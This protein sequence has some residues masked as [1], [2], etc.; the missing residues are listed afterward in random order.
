MH[1]REIRKEELSR[2]LF[3]HF[4]R[5]QVVTDCLRREGESWAVKPAPFVDD[6]TEEDY[7]FLVECLKGTI[8]KGGAVFGAFLEQEQEV[9][10]GFAS[11]EG[12]PMGSRG[13]YRDLTSLHVSEDMRGKGI[14]RELFFTACRWAL[15]HGGEKLY[16]S[17]HS[18][19]ETQK[20][21][22]AV[23]CTDAEEIIR[24]HADREP[25]DIQLE[26]S[27]ELSE[28]SKEGAIH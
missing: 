25:Y 7:A 14:G 1:Y 5:R 28:M 16:M 13:Q 2:S 4:H 9:L 23:G 15:E 11:V 19:I 10:K 27:L 26:K 6:W 12:V 24:E 22:R 17:S 21:Y 8:T 20:F 3:A 18:A